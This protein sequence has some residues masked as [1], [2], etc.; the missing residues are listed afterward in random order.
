MEGF[1]GEAAV[2]PAAGGAVFPA[3]AFPV[4]FSAGLAAPL[5]PF[6]SSLGG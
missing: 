1:A 6:P 3:G 2:F 4:D 5:A